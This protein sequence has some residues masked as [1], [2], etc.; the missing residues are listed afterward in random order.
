MALAAGFALPVV[1]WFVA[2]SVLLGWK[3]FS[4]IIFLAHP[5]LDNFKQTYTLIGQQM[6]IIPIQVVL[7]FL[8]LI[9]ICSTIVGLLFSGMS[10]KSVWVVFAALSC[11]LIIVLRR[12]LLSASFGV[13]L[14]YF[15]LFLTSFLLSV[16]LFR[17]KGNPF[18]LARSRE[19]F[20]ILLI[21][22]FSIYNSLSLVIFNDQNHYQMLVFPWL[23]CA[24]Y[25]HYLV[26]NKAISMLEN[27]DYNTIFRKG[28]IFLATSVIFLFPYV[29]APLSKLYRQYAFNRK[30]CEVK[31]RNLGT[32]YEK[33]LTLMT[34]DKGKIY[35]NSALLEEVNEV[36]QYLQENTLEEDYVFGGPS[37]TL[38]NFLADRRFPS[39]QMYFLFKFASPGQQEEIIREL[40]KNRPNYCICDGFFYD[41]SLFS[42]DLDISSFWNEYG[43]PEIGKYLSANYELDRRV[44]RFYLFKY[45]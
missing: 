36:V 31:S 13:L 40:I 34:S 7:S 22:I 44:G 29:E 30:Y 42:E 8:F 25:A 39:T 12:L 24:G 6:Q 28:G 43:Y 17:S 5:S 33:T 27:T 35:M 3:E 37:T 20:A 9:L 15:P 19:N 18:S 26:S 23:I 21:V 41:S 1:P 10:S 32:K 4:D 11:I 16:L 45:R 14:H 2:F 38:F